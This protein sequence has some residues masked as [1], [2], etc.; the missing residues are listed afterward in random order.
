MN[1]KLLMTFSAVFNATIGIACSFMPVEILTYFGITELTVLPLIIQLL[2]ALYLGFAI[3]NWTAKGNIIGG[4]YSKPVALG[5]FLH[6][7]AGGLAMVKYL[8]NHQDLTILLIPSILYL[9]FAFFFG[10]I[11]FGSPI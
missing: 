8:A 9:L 3:L 10:K 1:T 2:A 11:L 7:V 6:Y 5:N 4:I